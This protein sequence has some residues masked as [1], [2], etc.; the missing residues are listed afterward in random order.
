MSWPRRG[1]RFSPL[2]L[3]EPTHP[4]TPRRRRPTR[5]G[6][7]RVIAATVVLGFLVTGLAQS[8]IETS[9]D[10]FLP[11]HDPAV[12]HIDELARSFGGDPVVVLLEA[13]KAGQLLEQEQLLRLLKLEGKLSQLPGAAAVYGPA[14]TVNQIAGRLQELMAE[15]SGR[16]DAVRGRAYAEARERGAS[17]RE[18]AA[19]GERA[20]AEFDARYGRLL[21]QA[22]PAGL[23]TLSNQSFVNSVVYD[24]DGS[25]RAQ[26]HFVVPSRKAVA[27]LVRPRQDLDQAATEDLVEGIRAAVDAAGPR[28]ARTT[29]SG[30]PALAEALGNKVRHEIP[31]L[32][33]LALL[34]VGLC[35]FVVPW[36]R[37]RQRLLPLASALT[38]TAV[39]VALFGWLDRPLSLGVVAFL[40]VLLGIGSDFTTYLAQ[41]APLRVVLTVACATAVSFAALAV[42][43]L[44]FVRDLGIALAVGVLLATFSGLLLTGRGHRDSVAA[45]EEPPRQAD[46]E[47]TLTGD[48]TT[49]R[50]VRIGA[51]C[52]M[53]LIAAA[54]WGML[55]KIPVQ[56]DIQTLAAGLPAVADMQHA[57]HVIGSSGEI[58]LVMRGPDVTSPRA[59]AWMRTAHDIV[60]TRHGDQMRP[61][62]S[63][64][65]LL[66]FLGPTPSTEQIQAAIRILPPYLTG[67]VLKSDGSETVLYFGVDVNDVAGLGQLRDE[68]MTQLPPPPN[69]Y[70]AELAG[71]PILAAR[72]Y[73]VVS[74]NYYVINGI[75]IAAAGL[76]LAAGLARRR[77]ALRA[78][79]TA[80]LT[81]GICFFALWLLDMSLSPIT[82]A[83]GSLI[84]A[85]GC[86][87]TVLRAEAYRRHDNALRK[88]VTLVAAVS[89]V[90]Y[91]VLAFSGFA[92]IQQFGLL[93]AVAVTTS[94]LVA[95]FVVWAT[96]A[97]HH[98][99][100]QSNG[101]GEPASETRH[102]SQR[103]EHE[104]TT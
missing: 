62:L 27:I 65:E 10:S 92:A 6:V 68:L 79:A 1:L 4:E 15:L 101:N 63:L 69:G 33:G 96:S 16:R 81:T 19:A 11:S 99:A 86:E 25:P 64:P 97:P 48:R 60:V 40:P 23:P 85:V 91:L 84:A 78:V 74:D 3:R 24:R 59:L 5:R 73:E 9:V 7:T 87:F 49:S 76:V 51:L 54:G 50:S 28:T 8:R 22:M 41:R 67:S 90:G 46:D 20:T 39:V 72:G 71:L 43:P 45:T 2:R 36:R 66:G 75:G 38:A 100:G 52:A 26:W 37:R 70:Q 12:E 82:V 44:P 95:H 53:A 32:G 13:R 77:D 103:N 89:A 34:A 42:I 58:A 17:A 14:T 29:V 55:P 104:I 83:L 80:V 21:V 93:L 47:S 88:S 102:G 56:S 98:G 30:V 31:L 18:A 61:A 94:L 57:E 35:F